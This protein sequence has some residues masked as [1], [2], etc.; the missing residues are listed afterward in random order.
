MLDP[1]NM[2]A[3]ADNAEQRAEKYRQLCL[4]LEGCF[5]LLNGELSD[6]EWQGRLAVLAN[7]RVSCCLW[8]REGL[9]ET[10]S[11]SCYG[12][13][14]P[15]AR[16]WVDYLE[17]AIAAAQPKALALLESIP[18][19][20]QLLTPDR[21]VF[22]V[23]VSPVRIIIVLDKPLHADGWTDRDRENLLQHMKA[24]AKP[25]RIRRRRSWLED[26]LD[27]T[28][29]FVDSMPRAAIVL[30]PDRE[31]FATNALAEK[32]FDESDLMR[33]LDGKLE[34][35]DRAKTREL[36]HELQH[37]LALPKDSLD[38]YAWHRNL[39]DSTGPEGC[40]VTMRAFPF[41]NWRL[42]STARDRVLV[43]VLEVQDEMAV[44]SVEQIAEFYKLTKAQARVAGSLAAGNSI[45]GTAR[46]LNVSVNT[47]RTHLR[48]IYATMGV[49]DKSQLSARLS[50]TLTIPKNFGRALKRSV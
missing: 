13:L 8:W 3:D 9:P 43:M 17:P 5:D 25:V 41:E 20:P 39:S 32:L 14:Q 15:P 16:Q 29:K 27:L 38:N 50:R 36:K 1:I 28:N 12:D 10:I 7:C 24:I 19:S 33:N 23:E 4:V 48:A 6:E 49:D 34:F 40:M 22:C 18:G 31:I 11:Y 37:V 44:P 2:A 47:V 45:E 21:L 42:E 30:T 26:V 46:A 35:T